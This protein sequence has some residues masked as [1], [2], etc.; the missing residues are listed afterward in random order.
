[1]GHTHRLGGAQLWNR[2]KAQLNGSLP[3]RTQQE[4]TAP[5]QPKCPPGH[6]GHH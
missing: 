6:A 4:P 2:I 1:M 3:K 5:H